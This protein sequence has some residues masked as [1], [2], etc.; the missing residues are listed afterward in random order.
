MKRLHFSIPGEPVAKGRP[1]FTKFGRAYT[2][3]KTMNHEKKV[4]LCAQ[5]AVETIG[6]EK[7]STPDCVSVNMTFF[8]QIPKSWS[9]KKQEAMFG[10]PCAKTP[11][12]D[13]LVK[14]LDGLNGLEIWEDDRQ[15]T[16]IHAEKFWHTE[17]ETWVTIEVI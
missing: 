6:W 15:V 11:D 13:N 12:L 14:I 17:P 2:P 9:Q 10:K 1:R 16:S 4:A 3:A 8:M 7:V 5:R